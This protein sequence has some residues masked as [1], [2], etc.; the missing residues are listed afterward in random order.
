MENSRRHTLG[1]EERLKSRKQTDLLFREGKSF[2]VFPFRVVYRVLPGLTGRAQAGF[3]VSA[4]YFKKAVDRNRIKR[5]IREGYRLQKNQLL[6]RCEN[7]NK[8]LDV[9]FIY[10][11][12]EVPEYDLVFDKIHAA[13]KRLE[14]VIHENTASNT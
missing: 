10:T 8:N 12:N 4:R 6:Q 1:K 2:S 5:L 7:E 13:I 3:S 14:K 9:F 11:G